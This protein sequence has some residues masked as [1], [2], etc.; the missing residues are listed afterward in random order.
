[1]M[2]KNKSII[3]FTLFHLFAIYSLYDWL[4]FETVNVIAIILSFATLFYFVSNL[5]HTTQ[6]EDH[7]I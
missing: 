1:M 2:N 4:R 3:S 6:R 5:E 7:S